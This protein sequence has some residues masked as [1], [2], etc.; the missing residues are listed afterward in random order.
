MCELSINFPLSHVGFN[1]MKFSE[2][3]ALESFT[4]SGNDLIEFGDCSNDLHP[5]TRIKQDP[6]HDDVFP[7]DKS[8]EQLTFDSSVQEKIAKRKLKSLYRSNKRLY[9]KTKLVLDFLKNAIINEKALKTN[10]EV[11][12]K[13]TVIDTMS[14]AIKEC[15]RS[16]LEK[17]ADNLLEKIKSWSAAEPD[18]KEIISL[19]ESYKKAVSEYIHNKTKKTN[20]FTQPLTILSRKEHDQHIGKPN[21]K[22]ERYNVIWNT[23]D[24][25]FSFVELEI[26]D[27]IERM[28]KEEYE[29]EELKDE[30]LNMYAVNRLAAVAKMLQYCI[31]NGMTIN[32]FVEKRTYQKIKARLNQ[33]KSIGSAESC[34][35]SY[36]P[37]LDEFD[38]LISIGK[39]NL[40]L[41]IDLLKNQLSSWCRGTESGMERE[42]KV[43]ALKNRMLLE[44]IKSRIH[45]SK[46]PGIKKYRAI[47][48]CTSIET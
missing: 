46:S 13:D 40:D 36:L 4:S 15:I 39:Y 38:Y 22:K 3:T 37:G 41:T 31:D 34:D 18:H 1:P 12:V 16:P 9:K 35:S 2:D 29:V 10:M 21:S 14:T 6:F 25:F 5:L 44:S 47:S 17:Q 24:T 42:L 33:R 7:L 45:C 8:S 32:E 19:L 27:M 23:F 11:C 20:T 43:I 30:V 28:L 48:D 26:S